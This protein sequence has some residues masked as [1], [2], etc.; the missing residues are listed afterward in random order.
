MVQEFQDI[1]NAQGECKTCPHNECNEKATFQTC[2]QCD[3]TNDRNCLDWLEP[4]ESIQCRDYLDSCK[5]LITEN[6]K[7]VRGCTKD[8]Q[9]ITTNVIH[10]CQENNCNGGV[11]PQNRKKCYQ[12]S[13]EDCR[14]ELQEASVFYKYCENF[15]WNEECYG[16]TDGKYLIV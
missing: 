6:G 9:N 11:Y 15:L 8:L 13:G 1:C 3:S 7:T 16:F 12:C 4:S 14:E 10:E 2:Y 5:I